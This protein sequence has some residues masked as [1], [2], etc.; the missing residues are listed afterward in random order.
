MNATPKLITLLLLSLSIALARSST[1]C[2]QSEPTA[3]EL[4]RRGV[5]EREA[6][7]DD[8]ALALFTEAYARARSPVALAQM[9][10]AEQAL[11]RWLAAEQHMREALAQGEHGYIQRNRATLEAAYA[12]IAR[13]V[14]TLFVTANVE[15]ATVWVD[16]ERVATLPSDASIRV[17]VGEHRMEVRAPG[18]YNVSRPIDVRSES[19]SREEV[20]LRVALPV[21]EASPPRAIAPVV[22]VRDAPTTSLDRVE[23]GP[24]ART[25]ALWSGGIIAV[26]GAAIAHGLRESAAGRY[27]GQCVG[28]Q[29]P[30]APCASLRAE[31]T[32]E[33][34]VAVAGYAVGAGLLAWGTVDALLP[35]RVPRARVTSASVSASR[36]ALA[37]VVGGVF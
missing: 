27:N 14:G 13:R 36:G 6:G 11:G 2:A 22:V 28:E 5:V 7:H 30:S 9:A 23:R 34:G 29:D 31:G 33:L 37:I 12:V 17:L 16:G 8:A 3:D 18:H 24:R 35:R 21:D 32:I 20:T 4:V 25:W 10:A 1:V 15:G 26:A 19:P